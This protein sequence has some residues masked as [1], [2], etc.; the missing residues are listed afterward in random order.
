MTADSLRR[1]QFRTLLDELASK[2]GRGTELISVYITPDFDMNKVVQQLRDEQGTASNIKSKTTRKNVLGA[3]E[4]VV[5]FLR[6]YIETYRKPPPN[7]M[8][9]FC[10]N[11]AGRED[12]SDVQLYWIEPP[13][14]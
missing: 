1:Y 9:I 10:G 3:L 2:R 14:P 8:A 4:K 11:V 7:G 13:S 5:Q 12:V 6:T